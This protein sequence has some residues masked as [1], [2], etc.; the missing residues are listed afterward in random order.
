MCPFCGRP[1]A[2]VER[3]VAGPAAYTCN[4]C[5]ALCAELV[6]DP[7]PR[8]GDRMSWRADTDLATVLDALPRTVLAQSQAADHLARGV[9]PARELGATWPEV[10]AAL[11]TTRQSAGERFSGEE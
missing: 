3:I 11:G 6:A 9:G 7:R 10:G 8:A 5:A 2:V 1:S 4:D